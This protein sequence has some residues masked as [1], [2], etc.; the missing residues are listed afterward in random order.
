MNLKRNLYITMIAIIGVIVITV[1]GNIIIIGEKISAVFHTA[2]AEYIFYLLL[3]C[4]LYLK[5]IK[6]LLRIYRM[7]EFPPLDSDI[8]K[9]DEGEIKKLSKLLTTNCYHLNENEKEELLKK[10]DWDN[11]AKQTVKDKIKS[12]LKLRLEKSKSKIQGYA[13]TVFLTTSISQNGKVDS[14]VI[15][16][17]NIRMIYEMIMATGFRPKIT[18]LVKIYKNVLSTA[19][20]S[21][22]TSEALTGVGT[23]AITDAQDISTATDDMDLFGLLSK[24][25]VK[26]VILTSLADGMV[27]TLLTCRIGYITQKYLEAGPKAFYGEQRKETRKEAIIA[28][29]GLTKDIMSE[30]IKDVKDV[31]KD[32]IAEF[33]NKKA[34]ETVEAIE[35]KT[36]SAKEKLISF[37]S[38]GWFKKSEGVE[39]A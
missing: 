1:L 18:E 23:L 25:R 13:T 24:K 29:F 38:L 33:F 12:D 8:D 3:I 36:G 21:Y 37:F 28:S 30:T 14:F 16:L 2:I 7:P 31:T 22:I 27:N 6:P 5:L 9:L 35:E 39:P 32:K 4:L 11:E 17:M 34:N 20:F 19:L 10:L 26:G 15:S